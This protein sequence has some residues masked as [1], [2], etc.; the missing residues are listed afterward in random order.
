MAALQWRRNNGQSLNE[1]EWPAIWKLTEMKRFRGWHSEILWVSNAQ[2]VENGVEETWRAKWGPATPP[3]NPYEW[4]TESWRLWLATKFVK[5]LPQ[6]SFDG[7]EEVLGPAPLT[8]SHP[9][10]KLQG[11]TWIVFSLKLMKW[12]LFTL[13]VPQKV[14]MSDALTSKSLHTK[15]MIF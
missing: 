11:Y 6:L 3:D 12:L 14:T 8:S 5:E 7:W 4:E 15:G 1:G 9:T 13:F 10:D 2:R